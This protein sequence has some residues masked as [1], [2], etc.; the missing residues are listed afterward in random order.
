M[1]RLILRRRQKITFLTT[2]PKTM[3]CEGAAHDAFSVA[4]VVTVAVHNTIVSNFKGAVHDAIAAV[5]S[6]PRFLRRFLPKCPRGSRPRC[7]PT[8]PSQAS[9]K[10][11][12][13]PSQVAVGVHDAGPRSRPRCHHSR[14]SKIPS[15]VPSKMP[16]QSKSTMP[17][18]AFHDAFAVAIQ[19]AL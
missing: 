13:M 4:F 17:S 1:R 9:S 5:L 18:Q 16:S 10:P 15:Q 8:M 6:S 12:M 2:C 19:A 7:L 14:P 11:S 3:A